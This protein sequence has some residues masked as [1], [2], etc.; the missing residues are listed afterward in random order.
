MDGAPDGGEAQGLGLL[1]NLVTALLAVMIC[2]FLVL[3]ALFV[4][5]FPAPAAGPDLPDTI[6]LPAGQSAVAL[7]HGQGWYAVVTD[8]DEILIFDAGTGRLRQRVQVT[9]GD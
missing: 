9:A 4:I 2:G 6:A 8:A 7:T 3:I 5:R 1:R